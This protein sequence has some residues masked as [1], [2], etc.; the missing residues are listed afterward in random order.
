MNQISIGYTLSSEEQTPVDLIANAGKAEQ[1]GFQFLSISDHF[2]PWVE[3]QGQ[4]PFVW[5]VLGG[6]AQ[7]TKKI[8]VMT[9]VTCPIIRI[10][11]VIVAQASATTA[12]LFGNRFMLGVGTGENLNEHVVG[13][14]WPNIEIRQEML[15]E[16]VA[17]IRELWKGRLT[18]SQGSYFSVDQAKVYTLPQSPPPIIV[19]AIGPKSAAL[20]GKIG[21]A[22]VTTSPDAQVLQAF[23]QNGGEGKPIYGQITV[24]YDTDEQR[25]QKTA[26]KMWPN[27]AISG[28]ASQ[29]LPMPLHFE[30][31]AKSVT[32]DQISQQ[33]VCGN[34]KQ[35]HLAQIQ[36]YADAGFTH[37]YIHQIGH[38]QEEFMKFY[39]EQILP[40]FKGKDSSTA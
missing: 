35:K 27:S 7:V 4:S 11:P 39:Q 26:A 9:G 40:E 29:E 14:G 23:R 2:S 18:H 37:I 25:A 17:I 13:A 36:Q 22:L 34:D 5:A 12:A 15:Q 1:A 31:L 6:I 16:A 20:A 30:Q 3:A 21:D 28:Q 8:P 24:C 19:S 33:V 32:P 10:H 38:N